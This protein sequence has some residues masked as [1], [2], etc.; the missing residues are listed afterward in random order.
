M[1]TSHRTSLRGAGAAQRF[2]APRAALLAIAM[3]ALLAACGGGGGGGGDTTPPP[4]TAASFTRGAISGFGSVIV[5]GVRFDD[6]GAEV[7]DD[8]GQRHSVDDLKLGAQVEVEASEIDRSGGHGVATRI[9]FG[10]EIIGPVEAVD[11]AGQSLTVLGQTVIVGPRTVFDDQL[12]GGLAGITVASVLEVHAQFDAIRQA[13]VASRIE[14]EA[15]PAAYKLRGLVAALDSTAHTFTIGGATIQYGSATDVTPQLANGLRVRVLLSTTPAG[16]QWVATA[17]QAGERHP[18]DHGEAE[19][20]G[21]I[22]SWTSATQFSV[23]GLAVDARGASFPDGQDA[24]V[25]GATVE[26]EGTLVDGVLVATRV[27]LEDEEHEHQRGE[28]YEL[29]GQ[30]SGLDTASHRFN[31]R[32]LAVVYGDATA[33]RDLTEAGLADGLSVE[34]KGNLS[35]DG[36]EL[37]ATRISR[38]N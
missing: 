20:K 38:E 8:N 24:V 26:V 37:T 31:L 15:A 35:A 10:S 30:I 13:Y 11:V 25:L 29:H 7:L 18:E 3:A 36:T 19:V 27:H 9:R 2:G 23:D 34:V 17:V 4:V 28:D 22:D 32:G 21:L 5:N 14:A 1:S 33:W 12:A 16:G 6:T